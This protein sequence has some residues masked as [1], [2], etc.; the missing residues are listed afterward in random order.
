MA[1]SK[2]WYTSKTVIVNTLVIA[3]ASIQVL[4]DWLVAGDFSSVGLT[5]L[6]TGLINL[7]LRFMTS[8][9]IR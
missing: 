2:K 4:Q 3:G 9:A 7:A 6:A 5:V 8:E 1:Y